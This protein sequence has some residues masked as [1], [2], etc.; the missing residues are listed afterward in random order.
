MKILMVS[1]YPVFQNKIQGGIQAVATTLVSTLIGLEEIEHIYVLCFYVGQPPSRP[2][3][4]DRKLTKI[5]VK[6]P[7]ILEASTFFVVDRFRAW[8]IVNQ[9]RPD[10][11][12]GQG[13]GKD[14]FIA[15]HLRYPSLVTVHGV[16]SVEARLAPDSIRKNIAIWLA[17]RRMASTLNNANVVI[18][19]SRYDAE[20]VKTHV[21]GRHILIPNPI[22]SVFFQDENTRAND[23]N[24]V[25]REI[26]FAGVITPR[27]NIKGILRAF[28]EVFQ[29]M[30]GARLTLIGPEIDSSY[31]S[32]CKA[33]AI[34][35]GLEQYIQF[36]GH[37]EQSVLLKKLHD[38]ACVVLF[39]NEETSPTIVMQAMASAKP[40]ISSSVGGVPELVDSGKTGWIVSKGDEHS[41]SERILDLLRNDENRYRMG[42]RAKEYALGHF[43][44]TNV[45]NATLEAYK[46]ALGR[47]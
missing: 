18:S 32:E 16:S 10:I 1:P 20:I 17:D 47:K 14:G 28:N 40:V 23:D 6:A 43:Y 29:N 27:K 35:L 41:L 42:L 4:K 33:L 9:L 13:V 44:P 21:T 11:V 22:S 38:C 7:N 37:V 3:V 8:M 12:H 39:S 5:F 25:K 24:N 34:S 26:L 45:A 2:I 46:I 19:T 15:T 36:L 30:P 31:L